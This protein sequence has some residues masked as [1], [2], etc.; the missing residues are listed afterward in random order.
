MARHT[1]TAPDTSRQSAP[2]GPDPGP[3]QDGSVRPLLVMMLATL[4]L[5]MALIA[6]AATSIDPS[7][8]MTSL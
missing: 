8:V 1:G 2:L 5:A 7:L 6:L 4:T 3:V